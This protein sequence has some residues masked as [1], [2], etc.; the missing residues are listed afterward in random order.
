MFVVCVLQGKDSN[1]K[2]II[3]L[4]NDFGRCS[5]VQFRLAKMFLVVL[6]LIIDGFCSH[7]EH[8]KNSI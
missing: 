1:Q 8:V 4:T 6:S 5:R 7:F 3:G 2:K